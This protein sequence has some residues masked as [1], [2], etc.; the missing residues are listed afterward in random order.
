MIMADHAGAIREAR[1][2]L[3][4]GRLLAFLAATA[5]SSTDVIKRYLAEGQPLDELLMRAD[6]LEFSLTAAELG[7][8]TF[9]ITCGCSF[10][11]DAALGDTWEVVFRGNRVSSITHQLT[12]IT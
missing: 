2:L 4:E 6:S 8:D 3:S 10:G 12:W 9:E 1:E 5:S 7:P 11:P